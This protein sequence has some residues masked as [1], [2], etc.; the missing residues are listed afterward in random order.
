MLSSSSCRGR[1]ARLHPVA[2]SQ[3]G[4]ERQGGR[5]APPPPTE[6]M[7]WWEIGLKLAIVMRASYLGSCL[8]LTIAYCLAHCHQHSPLLFPISARKASFIQA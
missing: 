4:A 7:R 5:F 6:L 1:H 8:D 3:L 2:L